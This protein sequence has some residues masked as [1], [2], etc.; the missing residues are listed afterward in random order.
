MNNFLPRGEFQNEI[1]LPGF[2]GLKEGQP[3]W[4]VKI[5]FPNFLI[6]EIV[7]RELRELEKLDFK[8]RILKLRELIIC[9]SI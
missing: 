6:P 9:Y 8:T 5:S 1:L 2:S 3:S 7:S 4:R